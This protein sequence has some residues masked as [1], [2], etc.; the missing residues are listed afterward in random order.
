[1][2]HYSNYDLEWEVFSDILLLKSLVLV[3]LP[4]TLTIIKRMEI[5]WS[6]KPK[7][8]TNLITDTPLKVVQNNPSYYN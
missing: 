2:N 7:P 1:M 4:A 3:F 6:I 5:I 8:V